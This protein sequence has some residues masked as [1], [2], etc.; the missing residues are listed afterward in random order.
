MD[1]PRDSRI[2]KLILKH[3]KELEAQVCS[4]KRVIKDLLVFNY[5]VKRKSE[6]VNEQ[7]GKIK[8]LLDG[9][10]NEIC[11]FDIREGL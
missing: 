2:Y 4:D 1:D 11:S 6:I 9:Q 3:N 5:D 7:L 10:N 8:K